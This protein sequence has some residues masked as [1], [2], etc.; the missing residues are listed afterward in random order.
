MAKN[1]VISEAGK[2]MRTVAGAALGAAAVAA[3]GVV[4]SKLSGAIRQGGKDLEDAAPRLQKMSADT[5]TKPILPARQKRAAATRTAKSTRRK[6]AAKK[7]A[8]KGG[9]ATAKRRQTS[10]RKKR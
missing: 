8:K 4:V 6:A 7:A 3:T 2:V 10:A 9:K 5:V 1:N